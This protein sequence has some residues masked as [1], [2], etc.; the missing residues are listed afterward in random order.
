M[1]AR[2]TRAVAGALALSFSILLAGSARASEPSGPSDAAR[3]ATAEQLFREGVALLQRG[4]LRE[5]CAKLEKSQ[6][7]DPSAGTLLNLADCYERSGR[8]ASAWATFHAAARA[9]HERHRDDWE[10]LARRHAS[11]LEPRLKRLRFERVSPVAMMTVTLDGIA[12]GDAGWTS[13][14]PIDPGA[15]EVE[16]S[17]AGHLPWRHSLVVDDAAGT[18]VLPVPALQ[19]ALTKEAQERPESQ[20]TSPPEAESRVVR[21]TTRSPVA[22][23]VGV[24]SVVTGLAAA[25]TS[26]VLWRVSA[27]KRDDVTSECPAYPR[28]PSSLDPEARARLASTNDA[29]L[30][31]AHASTASAI[32]G[33]VLVAAGAGLY[34]WGRAKDPVVVSASPSS[35]SLSGRF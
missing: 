14:L 32:G 19:K 11:S 35:L 21:S 34:L 7:V 3:A 2:R 24:V 1:S 10:R 15:H 5:A 25:A 12:L 4:E 26:L 13:E 22:R 20:A 17:A 23:T 9:A 18:I 27:S 6:A 33:A 28:C 31:L 8:I 16:V 29:A 30:D